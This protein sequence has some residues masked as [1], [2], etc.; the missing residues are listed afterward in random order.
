MRA[1]WIAA[2]TSRAA[3]SMLRDRSNCSTTLE[4]PTALCEV[5]SVTP[6][7]TPRCRSSGVVT[8]VATVSG[9]APGSE[10]ETT[11]VGM[12]TFG[13]G[14]TGSRKKATP[15]DSASPMVSRVVATGRRMNGSAMLMARAQSACG[16]GCPPGWRASSCRYPARTRRRR[17]ALASRSKY[18]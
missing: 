16:A 15:P 18:R 9:L 17:T 11:M 12:S 6:A 1:A 14:D 13:N 8:L 7:M 5:I 3:P 10:A 4:L 2:S